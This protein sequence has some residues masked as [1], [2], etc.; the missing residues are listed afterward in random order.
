M[1]PGKKY[2]IYLFTIHFLNLYYVPRT[3]FGTSYKVVYKMDMVL[4][5]EMFLLV[6]KP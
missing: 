6:G 3:L 2:S 1:F 4:F 5:P